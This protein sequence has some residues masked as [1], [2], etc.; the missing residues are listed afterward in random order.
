MILYYKLRAFLVTLLLRLMPRNMPIVFKGPKS[1]LTLCEQVALLGFKKPL[2]VTDA[3]LASTPIVSD[4][5]KTLEDN[6]LEVVVYDGVL[7]D[8]TF[9]K[10]QEG[11]RLLSQNNCDAVV[12][13]GGGSVLDAGKMIA[14]LHSNP[15]SLDDFD[16]VG[17]AKNLPV[18]IFAVPTTAGTGSEVTLAAVIS[19]P[20]THKKVAVAD[21]KL[22]PSFVALDAAIMEGLPPGLTAATGVDA[23]THAVESYL[24]TASVPGTELHAKA[25]VRLIFEHLLTAYHHGD[26]LVARD[27]M[28][29][30]SFYA[31]AAFSKTSVG[32]VH[33]IAHQLGRLCGTPHGNANAMLL[34]EVLRA[35]GPIVH[36]RLADLAREVNIGEAGDS[37]AA[38]ATA[39]IDRIEAMRTE[40]GNA[41]KTQGDVNQPSG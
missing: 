7:P 28:V 27:A 24:S 9:D 41:A 25:A 17:Q 34:P 31:G 39:F 37:D 5:L 3:F 18:T 21:A 40:N 26:K 35:Y 6:G 19:D 13:V 32:Y 10:V 4:M 8:P 1:S 15:G 16:G 14:L 11:E 30:A 20:D 33:G 36:A 23:L 29:L 22:I 2:L 38:L 12:A